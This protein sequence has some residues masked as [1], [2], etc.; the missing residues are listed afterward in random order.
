MRGHAPA[1]EVLARTM[2]PTS[3]RSG[4]LC[5]SKVGLA[6]LDA[7]QP[8]RSSSQ[9]SRASGA[10]KGQAEGPTLTRAERRLP[11]PTGPPA[12]VPNGMQGSVGSLGRVVR[13]AATSGA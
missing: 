13:G 6:D 5:Q 11:A 9:P 8:E 1:G 3:S 12:G 2:P 7:N 10:P 4:L